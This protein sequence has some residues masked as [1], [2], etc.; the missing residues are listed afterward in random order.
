MND[1]TITR[2]TVQSAPQVRAFFMPVRLA[3]KGW[4]QVL[5]HT[6]KHDC[7]AN[8]QPPIA[9]QMKGLRRNQD[10]M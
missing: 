10:A 1:K 7:N 6:I 3:I 4:L 8:L 5:Y 9:V 2:K